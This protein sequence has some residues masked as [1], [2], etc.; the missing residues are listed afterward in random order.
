[1]DYPAALETS[2]GE[3]G[4]VTAP[5]MLIGLRHAHDS[6]DRGL[7][8]VVYKGHELLRRFTECHGTVLCREIRGNDRLPLKCGGV[9]RRA[10]EQ[11][12]E[13]L[14]R[15]ATNAISEESRQAFSRLYAH[16]AEHDFHCA[17][18]VLVQLRSTVGV[19]QTLRDAIAGFVGGTV[20]RGGTCSALTAGVVA[21]G[22]AVGSIERSRLRV[23]RMIGL[24]AV[25]GDALADKYNEFSKT[26]NLGHR[27]SNWF[28]KEFGSTQ[29][30]TLTRCDFSIADGVTQYI[31]SGTLQRCRTFADRVAREVDRVIEQVP[32]REASLEH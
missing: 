31:E 30:R 4:G 27:L 28:A 32:K 5:L 6:L 13:T 12:V 18:T 23:L 1:V 17:Q 8:I 25:G 9:V 15:A 14:A 29:C 20:F 19:D 2:G 16:F 21:L 3:C 7:P 24:M 10:P 11:Y 26:M 22:A